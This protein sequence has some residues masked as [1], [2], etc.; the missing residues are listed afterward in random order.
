MEEHLG[1][2]KSK[3]ISSADYRNGYKSEQINS[4]YSIMHIKI[5]Q[6]CKSTFEPYVVRRYQKDIPN[7]NQKIIST[8]AK[9]MTTQRIAEIIEDIYRFETSVYFIPNITEKI[10]PQIENQQNCLFSEAYPILY[11]DAIHYSVRDKGVIR[12]LA[13]CIILGINQDVLKKF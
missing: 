1:Y 11:I 9:G 10:I 13:T 7:I 2:G 12:K 5:P 6:N 4:S 8:Y 3:L